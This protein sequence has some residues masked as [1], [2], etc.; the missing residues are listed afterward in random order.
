LLPETEA[1]IEQALRRVAGEPIAERALEAA[2]KPRS[3]AG[4]LSSSGGL[5]P[6]DQPG[7]LTIGDLMR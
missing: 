6:S 7:Q 1:T 4:E 3:M 2:G 5:A